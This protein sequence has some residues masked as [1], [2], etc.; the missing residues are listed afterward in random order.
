MKRLRYKLK[1]LLSWV[2]V[3]IWAG[4]LRG[5]RIGLFT[6]SRFVRG[7]YGGDESQVL[8]SLIKPGDVVFDVGAHVGYYTML[9]S[10]IV[11]SGKVLSFEPLPLNLK[12]LNQHVR[13]NR[14]TNVEVIAAAVGRAE[15]WLSFDTGL[16]TG[17]GRLKTGSNESAMRVRVHSIDEL[18]RTGRAPRPNFIKM[19]IE[20]AEVDALRGAAGT[21][22]DCRP[23]I[24]LSTHGRE[25]R[26]E[27]ESLLKE[28]GYRLEPFG[29]SDLIAT[30]AEIAQTKAA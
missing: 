26:L 24:L 12:Y 2:L 19:D 6:G 14:L 10:K 20:G 29:H 21:L 15:G 17:R 8:A 25:V 7:T 3:P 1:Q 22:R 18:L 16:G 27:C 9:A 23:T 30:P 4:P 11:G 28:L 5:Y 13:A